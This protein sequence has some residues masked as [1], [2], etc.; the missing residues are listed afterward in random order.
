MAASSILQSGNWLI[1]VLGGADG[2]S[3]SVFTFSRGVVK[4]TV[5]P[6]I[7]GG[8]WAFALTCKPL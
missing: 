5:V 7:L 4:S 1:K 8:A 2:T 6:L 3:I